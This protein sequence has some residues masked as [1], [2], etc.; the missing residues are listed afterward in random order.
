MTPEEVKRIL[1]IMSYAD[2][3]CPYC[4]A[5]LFKR[6]KVTFPE[7]TSIVDEKVKEYE[8]SRYMED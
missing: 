1:D 2:G 4:V 3:A 8:L 5:D 6:F 7:F